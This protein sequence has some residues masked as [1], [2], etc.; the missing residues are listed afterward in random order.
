[1]F[2]FRSVIYLLYTFCCYLCTNNKYKYIV[3]I[4]TIGVIALYQILYVGYIGMILSVL[5]SHTDATSYIRC[6]HI[7]ILHPISDVICWLQWFCLSKFY[8]I[9]YLL[10]LHPISL[11]ITY[12]LM[13]HPISL[14]IT[15]LL[16]L[17][18][19]SDVFI[20]NSFIDTVC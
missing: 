14:V 7:L 3:Y 10:M 13:L 9:T 18:P 15:Y 12:L 19:I 20:S 5:L 6:Y 11:V 17:H 16:M 8:V 2:F 1:M 4:L